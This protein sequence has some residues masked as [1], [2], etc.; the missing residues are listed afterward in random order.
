MIINKSNEILFADDVFLSIF[1]SYQSR[2]DEKITH[3]LDHGFFLLPENAMLVTA[4]KTELKSEQKLM[5]Y[6]YKIDLS[7]EQFKRHSYL[8]NLTTVNY[9]GEKFSPT[10]IKLL[11]LLSQFKNVKAQDVANTL[12]VSQKSV[13]MY[14]YNLMNKVRSCFNS[15][16]INTALIELLKYSS[17]I[18]LMS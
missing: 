8:Q 14:K 1:K 15:G 9:Q 6:I 18:A 4:T 16:M 2:L 5:G 13:Y 12:N 17:L 11:L 3:Q 7:L 10:D